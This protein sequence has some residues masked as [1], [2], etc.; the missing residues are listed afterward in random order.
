MDYNSELI[1]AIEA[2][3]TADVWDLIYNNA[4]MVKCDIPFNPKWANGTGYF[5]GAV[6]A[7]LPELKIGEIG[8]SRAPLPDNRR[9]LLVKTPFGNV[10]LFERYTP[11]TDADVGVP[12]VLN[13]PDAVRISEMIGTEGAL[14]ARRLADVTGDSVIANVGER[15]ADFLE[16]ARY[17]LQTC[18]QRFRLLEALL[19]MVRN[20]P[21]IVNIIRLA[22]TED[23]AV[24]ALMQARWPIGP[25][26]KDAHEGNSIPFR[27]DGFGLNGEDRYRLTEWQAKAILSTPLHDLFGESLDRLADEYAKLAAEIDHSPSVSLGE[28][29]AA[30]K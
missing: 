18:R 17:G 19:I 11:K 8:R 5:N 20:L 24:K 28:L 27:S 22:G 4:E 10:V 12:I 26:I 7:D 23:Y 14:N 15:L 21:E 9:L 25:D 1:D 13:M 16:I 6:K 30:H 29:A 2:N 3:R